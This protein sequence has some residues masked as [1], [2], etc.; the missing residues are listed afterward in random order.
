MSGLD[1]L[2][3]LISSLLLRGGWVMFGCY[4]FYVLQGWLRVAVSY[5]FYSLVVMFIMSVV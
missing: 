4:V 1:V 5:L 3:V 2:F